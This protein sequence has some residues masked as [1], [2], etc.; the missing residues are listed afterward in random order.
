MAAATLFE[1]AVDQEGGQALAEDGPG[2]AVERAADAEVEEDHAAVGVEHQ[3]PG[4]HVAVE[5]AV[6][7]ARLPSMRGRLPSARR[8]GPQPVWSRAARSSIL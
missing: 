2:G 5:E 4:V 8:R 7:R 1:V 3:V 6:Y